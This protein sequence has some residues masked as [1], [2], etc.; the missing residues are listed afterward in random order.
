MLKRGITLVFGSLIMSQLPAQPIT[1]ESDVFN[2]L[3]TQQHWGLVQPGTA[4]VEQYT[5]KANG[6]VE[7][8]SHLERITGSYTQLVPTQNI[9]LP[10]VVIRF[11]T[12]NQQPDCMGDATNQAGKSTTNFLKKG[13]DQKIYFCDDALGKNCSVYLRPEH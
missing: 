10:A 8:K 4:C 13:A 3:K 1:I 6:E 2:T 7:I 5:F 9:E 12:D 11:E